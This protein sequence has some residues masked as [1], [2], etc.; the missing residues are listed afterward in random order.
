MAINY[1]RTVLGVGVSLLTMQ[2]LIGVGLKFL[3][4]LQASIGD[5]PDSGALVVL[6]VSVILLA[7]VS[8]KRAA[9]CHLDGALPVREI[10]Q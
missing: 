1:Y 5:N 2:L 9:H 3:Q 6:L 8:H 7:A 4:D 10:P